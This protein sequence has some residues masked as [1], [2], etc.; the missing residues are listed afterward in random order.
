MI[1]LISASQVT[2]ITDVSYWCLARWNCH[3]Y[4]ISK[5]GWIASCL[6]WSY[7]ITSWQWPEM[8]LDT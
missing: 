3:V 6:M 8:R 5:N 2:R 4:K 7:L 1:L